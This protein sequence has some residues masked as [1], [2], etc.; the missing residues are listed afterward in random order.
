MNIRASGRFGKTS[1]IIPPQYATGQVLAPSTD[2]K[3]YW[4][5]VLI[6]AQAIVLSL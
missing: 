2:A 1:L 3:A 5:S 4:N 6:T